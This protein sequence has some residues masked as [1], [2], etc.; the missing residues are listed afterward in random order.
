M[1]FKEK[2]ELDPVA[3]RLVKDGVVTVTVTFT[4][5][6]VDAWARVRRRHPKLGVT[7][8]VSMA[9]SDLS[10]IFKKHHLL[11]DLTKS[12][13]SPG[14]AES[15]TPGPSKKK[16]NVTS[17]RTTSPT[18][19]GI[20]IRGGRE[21]SMD[22]LRTM[23]TT[24]TGL[25]RMSAVLSEQTTESCESII[26]VDSLDQ[27]VLHG[28]R[29]QLPKDSITKFDCQRGPLHCFARMVAVANHLGNNKLVSRIRSSE[30]LRI[31]G[32]PDLKSWWLSATLQDKLILLSS[33]SKF[34]VPKVLTTLA[35]RQKRGLEA[36]PC[37]FRGPSEEM[38]LASHE[39]DRLYETDV[40][41]GDSE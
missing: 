33:N 13:S 2:F 35:D 23:P 37:P 30:N 29:N 39:D 41:G 8:S 38:V 40:D 15:P 20:V 21:A 25:E 19:P 32:V 12:P 31:P 36:L 5:D 28:L 18:N 1:D 11:G 6:G 3:A 7:P 34:N 10:E 26:K 17:Q 27:V 24:Q 14:S 4:Q 16:D 9:L 22:F